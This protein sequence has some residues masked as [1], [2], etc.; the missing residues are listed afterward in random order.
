MHLLVLADKAGAVFSAMRLSGQSYVQAFNVRHRRSGSLWQGRFKSC[1]V[2]TERYVLT[3]L[4]Y[5]ELN[6]VRAR[7]VALPT[8]YLV[9]RA[10][11]S[12]ACEEPTHE[13][14]GVRF[15]YQSTAL[16]LRGR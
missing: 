8:E 10:H 2:Q 16:G 9:K 6:P 7:L 1:L 4:R 12:G 15:T 11:A 3:A 14:N 5:I 13:N